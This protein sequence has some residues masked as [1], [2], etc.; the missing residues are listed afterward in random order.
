MWNIPMNLE[1][2]FMRRSWGEVVTYYVDDDG[3]FLSGLGSTVD[4]SL[5]DLYTE[6]KAVHDYPELFGNVAAPALSVAE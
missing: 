3:L 5:H 6:W 1:Y 2:V 4:D